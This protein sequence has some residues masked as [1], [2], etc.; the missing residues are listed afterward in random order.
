[1]S[2][3]CILSAKFMSELDCQMLFWIQLYFRAKPYEASKAWYPRYPFFFHHKKSDKCKFSW[4]C[5]TLENWE[6]H[7]LLTLL[8]KLLIIASEIIKERYEAKLFTLYWGFEFIGLIALVRRGLS[9]GNKYTETGNESTKRM[10]IL[11]PLKVHSL[12]YIAFKGLLEKEKEGRLLS[13]LS[14]KE[15]KH[16][17]VH[18][19]F[20]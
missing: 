3:S 10:L 13:Q 19:K 11:T 6:I 5:F 16:G 4:L 1:M 18:W 12:Q 14:R 2:S 20:L 15:N 17:S 8:R 9:C 7:H